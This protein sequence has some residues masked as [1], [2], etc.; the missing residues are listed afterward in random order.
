MLF[1][2]VAVLAEKKVIINAPPRQ[3]VQYEHPFI[4]QFFLGE[5]GLRALEPA[6]A[7]PTRPATPDG[8]SPAP[9]HPPT[10]EP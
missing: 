6:S 7:L 10:Q 3:V 2:S 5:R 1:R 9:S 8:T 4:Q